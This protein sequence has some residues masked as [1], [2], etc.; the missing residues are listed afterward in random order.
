MKKDRVMSL[1]QRLARRWLPNGCRVLDAEVVHQFRAKR[2]VRVDFTYPGC[3]AGDTASWRSD[4][5]DMVIVPQD[6]YLAWQRLKEPKMPP[7][8][9][10]LSTR[11][12]A[13]RWG[14]TTGAIRQMRNRGSG[15]R[16]FKPGGK[17]GKVRYA[18]D[19]VVAHEQNNR[20]GGDN[21]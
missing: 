6:G 13:E 16:Y 15:P 5:P 10:Y 9:A 2:F 11:E 3:P 17:N 21:A 19:D 18:M 14:M 8:K 7:T 12:L 20:H 1:A 4:R